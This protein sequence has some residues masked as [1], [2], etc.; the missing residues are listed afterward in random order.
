[1]LSTLH[2]EQVDAFDQYIQA[3]RPELADKE[4]EEAA[5]LTTFL[6]PQ[7]AEQEIDAI[8]K[9]VAAEQS[10]KLEDG[11]KAKGALIKAFFGKVDK[12]TCDSALV[13]KRVDAL[14][15]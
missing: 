7:L 1:M 15:G 5:F 10:V 3:G 4:T 11:K 12:S 13:S 6:P 14:L 8:L 9:E 2:L